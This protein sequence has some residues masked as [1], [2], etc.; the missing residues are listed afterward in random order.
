MI[1]F[2]DVYHCAFGGSKLSRIGCLK[3]M[4]EHFIRACSFKAWLITRYSE[5]LSAPPYTLEYAKELVIQ[6]PAQE[7]L[8]P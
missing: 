6:M 1:L 5:P 3:S 7:E 2:T 8:K 4:E